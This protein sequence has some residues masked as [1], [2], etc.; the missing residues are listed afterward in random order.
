MYDS[1][2]FPH[3]SNLSIA[4]RIEAYHIST[5]DLIRKGLKIEDIEKVLPSII[6]EE[7]FEAAEG[8]QRAINSFK[9]NPQLSIF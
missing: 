1:S 7:Y 9:L 4:E 8:I 2:D 6:D 5:L 3:L